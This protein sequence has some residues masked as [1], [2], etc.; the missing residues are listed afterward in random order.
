[1]SVTKFTWDR[2]VSLLIGQIGLG[3]GNVNGFY[4]VAVVR[5]KTDTTGT[6]NT[7]Y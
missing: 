1:M 2:A 6:G 5:A 3:T 7:V 4:W